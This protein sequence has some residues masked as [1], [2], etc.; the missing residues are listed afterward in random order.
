MA[1]LS[2]QNTSQQKQQQITIG[3]HNKESLL[4]DV[5]NENVLFALANKKPNQKPMM[6]EQDDFDMEDDEEIE[7]KATKRRGNP[8]SAISQQQADELKRQALDKIL[9]EQKKKYYDREKK[10]QA[11]NSEIFGQGVVGRYIQ[12]NQR[13]MMGNRQR[14]KQF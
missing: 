10:L 5:H 1:Y 14:P 12:Y 3:K 11:Q 4:N 7:E 2:K 13:T 8:K 9:E 6:G